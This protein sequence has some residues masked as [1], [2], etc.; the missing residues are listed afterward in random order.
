MIAPQK[1]KYRNYHMTQHSTPVYVPQRNENR[2]SK[3][4]FVYECSQQQC[5]QLP[6]GGNKLNVRQHINE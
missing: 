3:Q 2:Y 6:K 1:D 4:M 5:L